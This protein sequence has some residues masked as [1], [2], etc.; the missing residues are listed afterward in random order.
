MTSNNISSLSIEK[1][2]N[3]NT[4]PILCIIG[5]GMVSCKLCEELVA[6]KLNEEY[7]IIVIGAEDKP[8]YDR[9]RLTKYAKEKSLNDIILKDLSWYKENSIKLF[10]G[11][12]VKSIDTSSK[13]IIAE[14]DFRVRYSKLVFATGSSAFI[15]PI[16]GSNLE[17]TFVYRTYQ[18]VN[19]ISKYAESCRVAVVIGGGLLGL[20]AA[21]FLKNLG[22]KVHIVEQA[23]YLM[24]RQL[25]I[26][27][28]R[29]LMTKVKNLG[30]S[31]H[32]GIR[33]N[34]IDKGEN[35]SLNISLEGDETIS[36]DI[37]VFAAGVRANSDL[38]AEAGISCSSNKGI[39]VDDKLETS[40]KDIYAIGECI[41]HKGQIYGLVA[42]GYE[43]ARTLA[44]RLAGEDSL[45]IEADMS[46]RLKMLGEN[47]ISLGDALQPYRSIT[48]RDGETYRK[49]IHFENIIVG[50]IG[51]GE[52]QQ[53]GQIQTAIQNKMP[54]NDKEV[55]NFIKT[56]SLWKE[57]RRNIKKWP[58]ETLICNCM[59]VSK[60]TIIKE[61][62]SGNNTPSLLKQSCGAAS[63]CGSCEPLVQEL[64][65]QKVELRNKP[66]KTLLAFSLLTFCAVIAV[67]FTKPIWGGNSVNDLS[68]KVTKLLTDSVFRQT[69]GFTML[70]LTLF[71]AALSLRKRWA[72]FNF[73]SFKI[74]RIT[75]AII[76]FL[77]IIALMFHTGF[78]AGRN[79]NYILF[80][81]FVLI[82][83]FGSITGFA[84]AFEFFG[85][86]RLSAFCRRWK[87]QITF[88]HCLAF[89]PL[90]ILI[91]FHIIQVYYLG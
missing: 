91:V 7:E 84:S 47:V 42:P 80:S 20:E 1:D 87:S 59:K 2:I 45:F 19:K 11:K 72:K 67:I 68:Y 38:A 41:R 30:Y 85:M 5:N 74:W 71:A 10:L 21:E 48:Y 14:N 16:P 58:D 15:P 62:N 17:G 40:S 65:G 50:A 32:T 46:T 63:V 3:V 29:M 33:V 44:S 34:S 77:S 64:C 69:T 56:G 49:I 39:I 28:A 82:N 31:L 83:F 13:L 27:G 12:K 43:M 86:N 18:D 25:D 24:P 51:V 37:V 55:R 53:S 76:G 23:D 78:S 54:L 4:K 88:V 89:W 52:W 60:G 57:E 73:G 22:L 81:T 75:H 90:P 79:L 9:V 70:G 6:R 61:I 26:S 36:T 8:A 35:G 66:E